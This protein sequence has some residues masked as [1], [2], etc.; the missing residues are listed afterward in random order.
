MG[1]YKLILHVLILIFILLSIELSFLLHDRAIIHVN[2]TNEE[3]E[4]L[5][6]ISPITMGVD[7]DWKPF[8]YLSDKGYYEGIGADYI[9]L[10]E[11]KLNIQM[12]LVPTKSWGE[13]LEASKDSNVMILPLLNKTSEREQ[14]LTFSEPLIVDENVIIGRYDSP[15]ITNLKDEREKTVVLPE[16][17]SVEERL[18]KDYPNLKIVIV[19]S[20]EAAFEM[21]LNKGANFTIRSLIMAE[22]NI[23]RQGWFDL[24]V[25]GKV[26]GYTNYLSIGIL[27]KHERLKEILNKAILSITEQER[28][29]ILNKH[30]PLKVEIKD[31]RQT[32]LY[33]FRITLAILLISLLSWLFMFYRSRQILRFNKQ[34][35]GLNDR[36]KALSKLS[37]T[38]FWEINLEG[39]Y[40]FVSS[41]VKDVVGFGSNEML[42]KNYKTYLPDLQI[43]NM[44]EC[45]EFESS[46][47]NLEARHITLDNNA[48]WVK[49]DIMRIRD[50]AGNVIAF[51]GSCTDIEQR[52]YL[53]A[54]LVK[55]KNEVELAYYQSQ[56]KP[57]FLYNAMSAIALYCTT[58][59]KKASHLIME[60]SY[61]LKTR[62]DY[63]SVSQLVKLSQELELINAYLNIESVRF[64]DR[65]NVYFDIDDKLL[66]QKIPQMIL[67]PLVENAINHG[68]MK[69]IEG[70]SIRISVKKID[71]TAY[72][73]VKDDGV[74]INPDEIKKIELIE[75]GAKS[76]YLNDRAFSNKTGVGLVNIQERLIRL[77][78][79]GVKISTNKS[80]GTLVAFVLPIQTNKGG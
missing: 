42:G 35:Q 4:Y 11:K 31:Q 8:E 15:Y 40:T 68:I 22:Y 30:V 80:D 23:R 75:T 53:E 60:L 46:L 24:K 32:M 55:T 76:F 57:H 51:S 9:K 25:I 77:Y 69:K 48:I 12:K 18:R 36:Y 39:I 66:S 33:L 19:E 58:E 26:P 2:L 54:E 17:T 65:L 44:N 78:G 38:Y 41:E 14:W 13:T 71:N 10:I 79:T 52:K 64:K 56:I 63:D 27:K 20:E 61:F 37:R 7:P 3:K 6:S 59:P 5:Q 73:E 50:I 47:I 34:M 1:K 21:V 70:G 72:F 29:D 49:V 62:Y 28:V 74:G 67:Q 43:Q 16:G 45:N